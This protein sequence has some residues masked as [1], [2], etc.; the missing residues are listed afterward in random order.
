MWAGEHDRRCVA[1][2]SQRSAAPLDGRLA[3]LAGAGGG[4]GFRLDAQAV[5]QLLDLLGLDQ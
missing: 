5:E 4:P 2:A 3:Q 1:L